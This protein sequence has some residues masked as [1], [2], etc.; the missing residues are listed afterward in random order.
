MNSDESSV[1]RPLISV[2][3]PTMGRPSLF[4]AVDSVLAQEG[5][6]IEIIAV[7]NNTEDLPHF[8]DPRVRIVDA[9]KAPGQGPAR[10]IGAEN[11][12]SAIIALLDDDDFWHPRKCI[13]QIQDL[14]KFAPINSDNWIAA[15]GV[16]LHY[17]GGRQAL[18]PRIHEKP[19][20]TE[21][22]SEYLF[23]R[24]SL[25]RTDN[26]IQ[27]STLMFP[28]RMAM[29][30]PFDTL[31]EV[32]TDWGWVI[33]TNRA[34]ECQIIIGAGHR[35]H[36]DISGP[37]GVSKTNRTRKILAWADHMLSHSS[38]RVMGDFCATTPMQVTAHFGDVKGALAVLRHAYTKGRPGLPATLMACRSFLI[39]L[40]NYVKNRK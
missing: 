36:Y 10:Q 25:R 30:V 7:V 16:T 22:P 28:R 40:T 23:L 12:S 37:G 31:P 3:I 20:V 29:L 26:F 13:E 2:V 27:S 34:T 9:R 4:R 24:R 8:D 38:R 35:T 39:C 32:C 33:A 5:V 18:R 21:N 1:N 15:T 19:I 17:P 14:E 6:D 11:A